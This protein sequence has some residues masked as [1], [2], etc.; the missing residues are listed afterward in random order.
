M[1]KICTVENLILGSLVLPKISNLTRNSVNISGKS[2]GTVITIHTGITNQEYH[3]Y[4]SYHCVQ[5]KRQKSIYILAS[6][7]GV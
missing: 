7:H 3:P 6:Y 2:P 5:S 1:K 4:Y